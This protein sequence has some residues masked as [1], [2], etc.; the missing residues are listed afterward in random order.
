VRSYHQLMG[1]DAR[2]G[3]PRKG[4]LRELGLGWVDELLATPTADAGPAG[5]SV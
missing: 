5:R 4:K 1:W 2:T 3:R